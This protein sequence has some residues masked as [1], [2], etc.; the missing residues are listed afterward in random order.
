MN[1]RAY[2]LGGAKAIPSE[3]MEALSNLSGNRGT[4]A[5]DTPIRRCYCEL[6]GEEP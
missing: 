3:D 6:P 4:E 2:V 5:R 1:Y